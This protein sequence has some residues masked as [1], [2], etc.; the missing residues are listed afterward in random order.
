MNKKWYF[1]FFCYSHLDV[2]NATTFVIAPTV[3]VRT[4]SNPDRHASINTKTPPYAETAYP[5]SG[6]EVIA[7][8]ATAVFSFNDIEHVSRTRNNGP[9]PSCS[10]TIFL[11][12]SFAEAN[13]ETAKIACS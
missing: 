3:C 11:A 12:S 8:T 7:S 4:A 6:A 10:N 2:L 1:T 13:K 9:N 5:L